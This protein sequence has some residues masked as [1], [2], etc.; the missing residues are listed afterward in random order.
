MP[1]TLEIGQMPRT[2]E[3]RQMTT[4]LLVLGHAL[5]DGLESEVVLGGPE[6]AMHSAAIRRGG[7]ALRLSGG[8]RTSL[9][10]SGT[11]QSPSS[12]A[13]ACVAC[14]CVVAPSA[15]KAE[16]LLEA[17]SAVAQKPLLDAE[18]V[19]RCIYLTASYDS[20]EA[21]A[22]TAIEAL[23]T[24]VAAH[25]DESFIGLAWCEAAF[26]A[27]DSVCASA[28]IPGPVSR[29]CLGVCAADLVSALGRREAAESSAKARHSQALRPWANLA[30]RR[31]AQTLSGL[32]LAHGLPLST[33]SDVSDCVD[34]AESESASRQT[35]LSNAITES[36]VTEARC[37]PGGSFRRE[38]RVL[39]EEDPRG[40]WPQVPPRRSASRPSIPAETCTFPCRFRKS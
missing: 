23:G 9:Q 16:L 22:L 14:V 37:T 34:V 2:L 10:R 36:C 12:G 31:R 20:D 18:A 26:D 24:E 32:A 5:I 39:A 17:S 33:S 35:R 11:R 38:R 4:T 1:R 3:I 27:S 19:G 40:Q 13:P 6:A 25:Q 7:K 30:S 8:V 21:T 28:T 15:A 29:R